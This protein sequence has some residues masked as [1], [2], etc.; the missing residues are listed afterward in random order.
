M[1]MVFSTAN[2]HPRDGYDYWHEVL[3]KKI[4]DHDCTPESRQE[5]RAELQSGAIADINLAIVESTPMYCVATGRHV[6]HTNAE[7][8]IIVRQIAGVAILEEDGREAVLEAGDF[9]LLDPRRPMI[10]DYLRG[11]RALFI[12]IPRRQLEARVGHPGPVIARLIKPSEAEHRLTSAFLALLPAHTDK[13]GSAA[14]EILRDQALDLLAVSLARAMDGERPRISSARSL[15]LLNVRA[16]VEARLTD[17]ALNAETVAAAAGMSVRY[18]NAVLADD[19]TSIARLIWARR[20]ERCRR[21]LEDPSQRHRRISEI[22]YGWGFSDMTH[23][24][25]R[26]RAAY[27]LLPSEYRGR[28]RSL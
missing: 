1:Q 14:A 2:V 12:K 24:G 21:A 15:A 23:F 13:L 25:R 5:F 22:A 7:E 11:S 20:L 26:F 9:T 28:A 4:V 10:G 19:D 17:P 8:L 27:G 16:A 6:E 18:A 3:C